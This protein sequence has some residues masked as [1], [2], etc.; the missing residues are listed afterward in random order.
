MITL[1]LEFPNFAH[2]AV[3]VLRCLSEKRGFL[4]FPTLLG[5]V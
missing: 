1:R 5:V 2:V 3:W 4:G